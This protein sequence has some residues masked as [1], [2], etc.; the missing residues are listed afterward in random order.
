[1]KVVFIGGIY[2]PHEENE[3]RENSRFGLDNASNNLQWALIEGLSHFYDDL[4]VVSITPVR[5]FPQGYN[6]AYLKNT[7]FHYK[8]GYFTYCIGFINIILIK[9][10]S[11]FI[12]LKRTLNALIDG[13][14]DIIIINY[15]I[16]SH[17][18]R[19]IYGLKKKYSSLKTCLIIPDLPQHMNASSNFIYR[20]LKWIDYQIIF[21]LL[22]KIDSF[23]VLS[24]H[25]IKILPIENK[26]WLVLEGVYR[27]KN[28]F[29][30][31]INKNSSKIILYSG[32][33]SKKYGLTELLCAFSKIKSS[34]YSL[35]ICGSGDADDEI[36]SF[37]KSDNRII[38]WGN[39]PHSEVINLQKRSTVLVNPRT[40][41]NTF[42]K[43]SFP[44]KTIEY[45]ASGTPTIIHRLSGIPD[46]YFDYCFVPE[47]ED[48]EGLRQC[49]IN[50]CEKP[51]EELAAFGAKARSFIVDNKNPKMQAQKIYDLIDSL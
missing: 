46:E 35:W 27:E 20:F 16:N 7:R 25:M 13:K 40:S 14:E 48:E 12:N 9:H 28:D 50:V 44:S 51:A 42:T 38:F 39:L 2:P 30:R 17:K 10:I 26:P 21:R 31:N 18:L 6:K 23:V 3:I 15:G 22:N 24:K 19:V 43:Y 36:K 29:K 11:I 8:S 45:L 37:A 49:I 32:G 1:M 33:L 34:E 4:T 47:S 5:T 41:T